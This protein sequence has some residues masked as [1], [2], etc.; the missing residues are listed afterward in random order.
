MM[1]SHEKW[2]IHLDLVHKEYANSMFRFPELYYKRS[3]QD[4]DYGHPERVFLS[5]IFQPIGQISQII[6][7]VSKDHC[8]AH[9]KFW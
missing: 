9:Y 2:S 4:T 1:T 8:R 3:K 6:C 7:K 5:Q